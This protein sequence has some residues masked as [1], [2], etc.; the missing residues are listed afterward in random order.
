[1]PAN[2]STAAEVTQPLDV[3]GA[4]TVAIGT[5]L[6]AL[7]GLVLLVF[8][9]DR[10]TADGRDWWLWTCVAGVGLGLLG[11]SYCRR[12]RDRLMGRRGPRPVR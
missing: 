8:F 5:A 1:M 10:L 4:T 6:W 11:W 12:R 7:S 3:D 2:P 9:R